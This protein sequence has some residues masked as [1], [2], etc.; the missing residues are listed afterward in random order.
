[1]VK[2]IEE[3]LD[4]LTYISRLKYALEHGCA[5]ITFQEDRRVDEEKDE[6]YTNRYTMA[7]LF[8]DQDPVAV[9]KNELTLIKVEEYVETVKDL[10]FR[11]RS[12]MRI[13]GRYYNT[14]EVY[15]KIRVELM[16]ASS[17]GVNDTVFVMSYHNSTIPFKNVTFPYR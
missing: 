1:M 15:I 10:R 11:K 2:R 9:L 6:M 7:E 14:N 13:F 16:K 8:P 5:Q 3:K 17:A 4:V 12:E